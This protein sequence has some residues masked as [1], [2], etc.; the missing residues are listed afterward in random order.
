MFR[1]FSVNFAIL[2]IALDT[3]LTLAALMLAVVLRPILPTFP[4]LIPALD[5]HIPFE[6]Y[7][8]TPFLWSLAFFLFLYRIFKPY[9][10]H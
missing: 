10:P 1:R 8:V 7:I 3:G 9:S 6:L 5:V 2:S 4:F